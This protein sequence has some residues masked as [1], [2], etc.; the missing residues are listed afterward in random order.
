MGNGVVS[1][2]WNAVFSRP[3]SV[4]SDDE[5]LKLHERLQCIE[6]DQLPEHQYRDFLELMRLV[7]V[8]GEIKVNANNG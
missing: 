1:D 4:L 8:R 7:L 3:L 6:I 5:L 2:D